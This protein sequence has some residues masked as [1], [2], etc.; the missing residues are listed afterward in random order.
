VV[1]H[2]FRRSFRN[3]VSDNRPEDAEPAEKAL[4]HY[5][6]R[7]TASGAYR[8]SDLLPAREKLMAAWCDF[9]T[10]TVRGT[11]ARAAAT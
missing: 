6:E 10:D 5:P 2:G 4:A 3:W 7:G 11:R 1:P 9:V 8:T